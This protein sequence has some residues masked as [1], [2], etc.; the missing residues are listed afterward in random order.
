MGRGDHGKPVI[1]KRSVGHARERT[2]LATVLLLLIAV[3]PASGQVAIVSVVDSGGNVGRGSAVAYGPDGLALISYVDVTNGALKVAHCNDVACITAVTHTLDGSGNVGG[4]ATAIAFGPDGRGLISYQAGG[5]V[6]V[7]HCADTICSS[8]T[9]S[10]VDALATAVGTAIAM[11]TDGRGVIAYAGIA[12]AL[13]IAYCLNADCSSAIVTAFP[14]H[15]G[16]N[17]TLTIGGDGLPLV[18]CDGPN[19]VDVRVGHCNDQACSTASFITLFPAWP[20]NLIRRPSLATGSD[21]LGLLASIL[22]D[23]TAVGI[24]YYTAVWRCADAACSSVTA[25]PGGTAWGEAFEDY[26]DLALGLMPGDLPVIAKHRDDRL[27]V[28]RCPNP[29]CSPQ[30]H[31]VVDGVGTGV[32]PALAVGPAGLALVTYYDGVNQDL[33]AAYM[34]P[35]GDS[36]ISIG[37]VTVVEGSGGNTAAVFEVHQ[38]GTGGASVQYATAGGTAAAGVDYM[39]ASG[40]VNFPPG[41]TSQT[42]TVQVVGDVNVEPDETFFVNLSSPQG[43]AILDG[44]GQGT[45]VDDDV[46][47][48]T[49]V[50]ELA[51]GSRYAGDL[52]ADPGPVADVDRFRIAL[53]AYSSYEVV[54][55]AVSGDVQP[56]ELTRTAP[57]G[58]TVVQMATPVGAGFSFRM[59]MM[60][61][62]TP[63]LNQF[64][65]VRSGGCGTEC[66]TDDV[67]QLRFYET[68]LAGARFNN[69]GTQITVLLLQ[70]PTE[71][72]VDAA[73]HFWSPQGTLLATHAP[74]APLAPK[75]TLVV[76]TAQIPGLSGIGGSV[77]VT[78]M[79]PDGGLSG[80][81]VAL[82]PETGFGFD[83]P[84]L[85]RRP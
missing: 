76:D 64:V 72:P 23:G 16:D 85:P 43:A 28:S 55:D 39:S 31:D 70:N 20:A 79:A 83:T 10:N 38:T 21:G 27:V 22:G 54:A 4:G 44:T 60:T 37:D 18:A 33:K 48:L 51:H 71:L 82:E 30:Q 26:F 36:L 69:S 42:I 5:A 24:Y 65:R 41:S 9:L 19:M 29:A 56:F 3:L 73:I 68:T 84:L 8:A 57:D 53:A 77:T 80:K 11:G 61:S 74:G 6:K 15:G 45:I 34:Q 67:Y 59:P 63:V 58:N 14:G 1:G 2:G 47:P 78:H 81:T 46:A 7:A 52:A 35:L 13:K 25:A 75:T 40:T 12:D 66:G 50:T 62:S 17:P 49:V 32:D